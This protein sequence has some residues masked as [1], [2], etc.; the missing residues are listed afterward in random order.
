MATI[1]N[2]NSSKASEKD[3]SYYNVIFANNVNVIIYLGGIIHVIMICVAIY[4]SFKC[5]PRFDPLHF[6]AALFLPPFYLIYVFAFKWKQCK[7]VSET[8][9]NI[10][11]DNR[12]GSFSDILKFDPP[13]T[14]PKPEPES[15]PES[16]PEPDPEPDQLTKTRQDDSLLGNMPDLSMGM[17]S[18]QLPVPVESDFKEKIDTGMDLF[19]AEGRNLG[20][21]KMEDEEKEQDGFISVKEEDLGPIA[22]LVG[23]DSGPTIPSNANIPNPSN[24]NDDD[25]DD[26]LS[27]FNP[28]P[29]ASKTNSVRTNNASANNKRN[30]KRNNASANN[31]QNNASANNKRNNKRNNAS[32]NNKRNNIRNN[33]RNNIRTN[34]A[35]PIAP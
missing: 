15:E 14:N 20:Q 34:N 2:M 1:V 7:F 4:F 13:K 12:L 17:A 27:T 19:R 11:P 10:Q 16:E 23:A 9:R 8:S 18:P 35:R 32:A 33:K 24:K 28:R 26:D 22:P 25:S 29:I 31:K 5:T 21:M 30:N 3:P 6:T